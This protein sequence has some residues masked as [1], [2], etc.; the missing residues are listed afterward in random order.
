M[1]LLAYD[2]ARKLF[3]STWIENVGTGM[4][5]LEGTWDEASKTI[6]LSGNMV[7]PSAGTGKQMPI[8]EIFK[9]IDD[10]TQ[11]MEMYG[12]APDGK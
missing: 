7:D 12:P 1:S 8:N 6:N 4:M 5:V 10:K 11:L 3:I 9:I 2:N